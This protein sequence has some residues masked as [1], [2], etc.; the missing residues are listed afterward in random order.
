MNKKYPLPFTLLS[1]ILLLSAM[2]LGGCQSGGS[3]KLASIQSAKKLVVYTNAEF[4]PF[5][6]I[7]GDAVV[8]VDMDIAKAIADDLGVELEINDAPFDG[9]ITSLASGRG[10]IAISGFTIREDRKEMVD[11]SK[12]YINSVQY[13]ILPADSDIE[14]MEDLGGKRVGAALGY[15]GEFVLDDEIEDGALT[16]AGVQKITVNSAIDGAL[17]I[18]NNR[19][20][21]VVMDEFVAIKIAGDYDALKAIKLV[22]EDGGD[23]AEEYGVAVPKGNQA[24]VDRINKVIDALNNDGKIAQWMVVH[25]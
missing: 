10:D 13:L 18:L 22:Y 12:P 11:F 5:E 1:I 6:Y 16:D 8:G 4:P 7:S 25:S 15:T 21:A 17:D 9:I 24:L 19:L 2:L 14:T 3:G 23:V 20:D